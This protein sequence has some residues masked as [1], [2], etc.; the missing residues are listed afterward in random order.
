M[1]EYLLVIVKLTTYLQKN[2]TRFILKEHTENYKE[3]ERIKVFKIKD[4]KNLT[5]S[6][7]IFIKPN[8]D[9]F[10]IFLLFLTCLISEVSPHEN[11]CG[12][13]KYLIPSCHLSNVQKLYND[14]YFFGKS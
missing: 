1:K 12:L 2:K 5:L 13:F 4:F 11:L 8:L 7:K 9:L 14:P 3:F 6:S 10:F